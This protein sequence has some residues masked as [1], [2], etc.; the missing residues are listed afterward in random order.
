MYEPRP[1]KIQLDRQAEIF[2]FTSPASVTAFHESCGLPNG[3]Y[4]S[5]GRTTSEALRALGLKYV[6]QAPFTT[7]EALCDLVSGL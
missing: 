4:V 7:E 3:Q 1:R 6:H 2:V 5:I